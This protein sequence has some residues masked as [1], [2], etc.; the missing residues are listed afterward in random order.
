[1]TDVQTVF[2][3]DDDENIRSMLEKSLSFHG[4]LV[5]S[6]ASAVAFLES[7]QADRSGCLLLDYHMPDMNGFELQQILIARQICN[8][9]IFI[10][11]HGDVAKSVQALKAGAFDFLEK[12]FSQDTLYNL[13]NDA[14]TAD[15]RHRT[16][17]ELTESH[18]ARFN[19]LTEREFQIM[20]LLIS[21]TANHSSK[22]I[23]KELD[24][25]PRTVDHHRTRVLEKT[26]AH[27]IAEL[28]KFA[29]LAGIL[30]L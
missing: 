27:S 11:G 20:R 3:I 15:Q 26:H 14:F 18:R 23:A 16:E 17:S 29:N 2:L 8:P 28:V 19:N 9:I 25:S 6:F 5:E 7:F 13:L 22:Q 12:P 10:T 1:M 4:F 24:I 30:S 21:G